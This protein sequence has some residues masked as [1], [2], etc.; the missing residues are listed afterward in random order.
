MPSVLTLKEL[1]CH[2]LTVQDGAIVRDVLVV[3]APSGDAWTLV[4][5]DDGTFRAAWRLDLEPGQELGT[6]GLAL[7]AVARLQD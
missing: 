6:E 4:S 3:N 1:Q 5:D 2:H 7:A